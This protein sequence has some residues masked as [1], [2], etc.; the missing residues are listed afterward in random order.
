VRR[1]NTLFAYN[2]KTRKLEPTKIGAAGGIVGLGWSGD[3]SLVGLMAS[4]RLIRYRPSDEKVTGVQTKS[5]RE[6]T[7]IQSI[8]RG[9]D[10]RIYCGGY[11]V[12]GLGA[13]DPATGKHEQYNPISQAEG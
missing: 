1:Q 5:P 11:L 10:G 3:D 13:Y 7:P 4:G 9:P 12:G 6:S 8:R 2:P